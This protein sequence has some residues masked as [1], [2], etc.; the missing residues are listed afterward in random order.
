MAA[1]C[2]PNVTTRS[3]GI[4][5]IAPD[6]SQPAAARIALCLSGG[7]FRATFFHLG[8]VKFLFDTQ[9]IGRVTDVFSVSGGA[10]LAGHL[11]TEW[12][13][14]QE[15]FGKAVRPLI[16]FG[17]ADVTGH[18]LRRLIPLWPTWPWR[19]T[20]LEKLYARALY[21]RSTLASLA[22]PTPKGRER[23]R[24]HFL[25]TSLTEG[26]PFCFNANGFIT[27]TPTGE[28]VS[29]RDAAEAVASFPLARAVAASSAFPPWLPPV[30]VRRTDLARRDSGERFL[31]ESDVADGGVFDNVGLNA[32]LRLRTRLGFDEIIVSDASAAFSL[33]LDGRYWTA[34]LLRRTTDILMHRVALLERQRATSRHRDAEALTWIEIDQDLAQ[35]RTDLDAFSREE[36]RV[37]TW[38]GYKQAGGVL[39]TEPPESDLWDPCAAR[40]QWVT[41]VRDV[42]GRLPLKDVRDLDK[43]LKPRTEALRD[44]PTLQWRAVRFVARNL[45]RWLWCWHDW[46]YMVTIVFAIAA[47]YFFMPPARVGPPLQ[48]ASEVRVPID[49]IGDGRVFESNETFAI[50]PDGRQLVVATGTASQTAGMNLFDVQGGG[51]AVEIPGTAGARAPFFCSG[52]GG[53]LQPERALGFAVDRALMLIRYRPRADGRATWGS[54]QE[55]CGDCIGATTYGVSCEAGV[56]VF[57]SSRGPGLWIMHLG[58]EGQGAAP[59]RILV[60]TGDDVAY[61][62]P[63]VLS[64][65]EVFFSAYLKN[66]AEEVRLLSSQGQRKVIAHGSHPKVVNHGHLV[67][68]SDG[69]LRSVDIDPAFG[70]I[71]RA[72]TT[73]GREDCAGMPFAVSPNGVVACIP[74]AAAGERR[75]LLLN[76]WG[77]WEAPIVSSIGPAQGTPF[78]A[79]PTF[80]DSDWIAVSSSVPPTRE[81]DLFRRRHSARSAVRIGHT[82]FADLTHPTWACNGDA[83]VYSA[84]AGKRGMYFTDTRALGGDRPDVAGVAVTEKGTS[85]DSAV[86]Y[87]AL[88]PTSL[89]V[90]QPDGD[91]EP[92]RLTLQD[93]CPTP[94]PNGGDVADLHCGPG[95][96]YAAYSPT[97]APKLACAGY[98]RIHVVSAEGELASVAGTDPV[99]CG[100]KLLYRVGDEL[101]LLG[102]P[103]RLNLEPVTATTF[104][105]SH[106][107]LGHPNYACSSEDLLAVVATETR[108]TR[109]VVAPLELTTERKQ[110]LSLRARGVFGRLARR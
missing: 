25:A 11:A 85:T 1:N 78:Y 103:Y 3:P 104:Y 80:R 84:N 18:V 58:P 51:E 83:L 16:R 15:D 19:T 47:L 57:A 22:R 9:V 96:T 12:D 40:W 8:V 100:S 2:D 75:L 6:P 45:R 76:P 50:S 67:F 10:I 49:L 97:A 5:H 39:R 56:L 26:G 93:V 102:Q 61:R 21:G 65:T 99:W 55:L 24:F 59:S 68:A 13:A 63:D 91:W 4:E 74:R 82:V 109:V 36:I 42:F 64:A 32:A 60:P 38:S 23:P 17:R 105:V 108:S 62:W 46:R 20:G 79:S 66:G 89:L 92:Q 52:V 43:R 77:R 48:A 30:K 87:S 90:G 71:G 81:I 73:F 31:L 35:I 95:T 110:W 69:A 107:T 88:R 14:Y 41:K 94:A 44:V 106:G 33:R 86:P 34:S 53:M 28:D 7:G 29:N 98:G 37:L 72:V 27:L 70:T 54:P 101:R